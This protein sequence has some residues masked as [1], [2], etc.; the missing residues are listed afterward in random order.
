MTFR[1]LLYPLG[2]FPFSGYRAAAWHGESLDR[3]LEDLGVNLYSSM[4]PNFPGP[5][6][7]GEVRGEIWT[8]N[9]LDLGS[10]SGLST[11]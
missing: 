5:L 6:G 10:N 7:G 4:R 11:V 1:K 2:L 9:M 8:L 3:E